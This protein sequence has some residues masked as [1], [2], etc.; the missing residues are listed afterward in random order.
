M[1]KKLDEYSPKIYLYDNIN[2]KYKIL[3]NE[4]KN[5]LNTNN[6]LNE[7]FNENKKKKMKLIWIIKI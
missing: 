1:K 6:T 2:E 4:H 3:M 5:L 7:L